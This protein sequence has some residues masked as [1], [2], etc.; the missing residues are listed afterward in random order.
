MIHVGNTGW[1]WQWVRCYH[2]P[3]AYGQ[4]TVFLS[5]TSSLYTNPRA[6]SRAL[7]HT[8]THTDI[9]LCSHS[10]RYCHLLILFAFNLSHFFLPSSPMSISWFIVLT[11]LFTIISNLSSSFYLIHYNRAAAATTDNKP[12]QDFSYFLLSLLWLTYFLPEN[13]LTN[14]TNAAPTTNL[15]IVSY[16]RRRQQPMVVIHDLRRSRL[17]VTRTWNRTPPPLTEG[18]SRTS[19]ALINFVEILMHTVDHDT[20]NNL[21]MKSLFICFG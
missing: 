12:P 17:G 6:H 7:S 11:P 14:S 1:L 8:H 16:G 10:P 2:L 15:H 13:R 20:V 9:Y 4:T 18:G 5:A 21:K 19:A 3:F